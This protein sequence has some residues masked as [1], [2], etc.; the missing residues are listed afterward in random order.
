MHNYPRFFSKS[1]AHWKNIIFKLL[2]DSE[3]ANE[4][5]TS[6][7]DV[8][9]SNPCGEDEERNCRSLVN[10]K[11]FAQYLNLDFDTLPVGMEE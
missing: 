2:S 9:E 8:L 10:P 4:N 6:D 7:S 1:Y 11:S 3:S 5:Y